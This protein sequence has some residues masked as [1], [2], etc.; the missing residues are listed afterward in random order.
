[1]TLLEEL[2]ELYAARAELMAEYREA[3]RLSHVT[4]FSVST[5]DGSQSEG[6][7]DP[8]QILQNIKDNDALIASLERQVSGGTSVHYS[9]LRMR[10]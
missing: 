2:T 4:N 10:P 8:A 1:M 7:R 9:S 6:R 5:P 3:V